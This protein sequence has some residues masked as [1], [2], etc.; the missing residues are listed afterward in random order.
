MTDLENN[1]GLV[2]KNTDEDLLDANFLPA[3]H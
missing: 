3:D 2:K 1:E